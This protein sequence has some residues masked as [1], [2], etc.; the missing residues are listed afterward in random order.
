MKFTH[1]TFAIL[2]TFLGCLCMAQPSVTL[3]PDFKNSTYNTNISEEEVNEI[4]AQWEKDNAEIQAYA[5]AN[6]IKDIHWLNSGLFYSIEKQGSGTVPTINSAVKVKY[7]LTTLGGAAVWSTDKTGG[8]E[9]RALKDFVYGVAEGLQLLK[10]G[11]KIM[12]LIPSGLAYGK[13]G[14]GKKIPAN[15]NIIYNIELLEVYN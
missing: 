7:T 15:T 6:N 2:F 9:V 8:T 10:P 14:W 12:L 13:Q 3:K 4:N 1:T 11:G 5:L